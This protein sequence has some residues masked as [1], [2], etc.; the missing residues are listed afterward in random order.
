MRD[1]C[2]PKYLVKL[3]QTLSY[4]ESNKLVLG[5]NTYIYEVFVPG[6]KPHLLFAKKKRLLIDK[7]NSL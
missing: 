1:H 7:I 5:F 6:G 3:S 4:S 2:F